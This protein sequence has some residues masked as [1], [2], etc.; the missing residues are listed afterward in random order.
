MI[1]ILKKLFASKDPPLARKW[2]GTVHAAFACGPDTDPDHFF[3]H[4]YEVEDGTRTYV[5]HGNSRI[6]PK[7][8]PRY[9]LGV[10]PW[11]ETGDR[12]YINSLLEAKSHDFY[13]SAPSRQKP[14]FKLLK[15]EKKDDEQCNTVPD[16]K[17]SN[18]A[19]KKTTKPS[20]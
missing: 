17:T 3:F 20:S 7:N 8:H 19:T 12:K 13:T 11:V 1:K 18:R 15:F 10:L 2:I 9:N 6:S 14:E 16:R 4:L 5:I